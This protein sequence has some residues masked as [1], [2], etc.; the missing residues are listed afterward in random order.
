MQED[1]YQKLIEYRN[2]TNIFA[3]ENG[4]L[5]TV[6]REG[7]AEV[8]LAVQPHHLNSIGSVHGGCLFT[9]ADVCT[10][11]AAFSYGMKMTTMNSSFHFLRAGIGCSKLIGRSTV[12]KRGRRACVLRTDIFD[13]DEKL[14]CTGTF[15]SMSLDKPIEL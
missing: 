1:F 12:I 6:I 3:S 2:K 10:G 13:Q 9:I 8:E 5:T 14:L 15:T 4:I 11:S 7:Y